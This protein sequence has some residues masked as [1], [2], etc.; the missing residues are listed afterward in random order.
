MDTI[1]R[2][3]TPRILTALV[4]TPAVMLVGPRQAGKSTLVQSLAGGPHP[5]RYLTLDDLRT[6]DAARRDPVGFIESLDGPV[7]IDEIQRAPELLLP[8]KAAIDRDRR[9]GRF[10][11]TGSAQVMLLP[12]MSES[13][14]GRIEVHTLWPF[15]Q[16]EIEGVRSRIIEMLLDDSPQGAPTPA[17]TREELI[18]R[19]VR[20]GFP[21]AV[22]REDD[23]RGEWLDSYL[24]VIVQRDLRDLANIERLAQVPAVLATLASRVRAPLNKT[25]V[26]SSIGIPRTSLD[27][28]LTLLENV[29]LLYRLP[30]WHTNRI[31]QI[32]KAPKLLLSDSALLTHLL[33]TDRERLSDDDS[34][35][36]VILESFVGMELAKQLSAAS[37][38][39]SLLHM[40]T[41]TGT[42]VDFVLE[43]ADG[44]LAGIEVKSSATVRGE[45]FKHLT[46]MRDRI[47][48]KR[49][50]RGVVLYTGSERL[51]FGERLEAWPLATLWANTA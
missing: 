32:A 38:R 11:L 35:L 13:L 39:A 9:P 51:P 42:E 40:R 25:E 8:I 43:A 12:A 30:A 33:R 47:D 3:I 23:R 15:S 24:T 26:G 17:G 44:R 14:A 41:A 2:A 20:G 21:E 27:R 6:L 16:A 4:D 31:K 29:F 50:V 45:D 34:L 48:P 37:T 1:S 46:A 28:Y 7:I 10:I 36:G 49:F 19:I 5:A 22:A 18:A